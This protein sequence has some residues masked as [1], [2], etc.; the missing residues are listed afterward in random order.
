VGAASTFALTGRLDDAQRA[1]LRLGAGAVLEGSVRMAAGRL[2]VNVHL[3]SVREGFDLWSERYERDASELARVEDEIVRGIAAGAAAQKTMSERGALNP[4][5]MALYHDPDVVRAH[6][7]F[8][9]V[10]ELMLRARPRPVTPYY[11]MLS[12]TLQP[13]FSAALVGVKSPHDAVAHARRQ[14]AYLLEGLQ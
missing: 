8:P 14:L 9:V 6:P 1:G 11:L 5:R 4:T 10:Y 12:T 3:V 13:E 2:T 7:D